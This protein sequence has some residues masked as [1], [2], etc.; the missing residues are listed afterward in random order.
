MS[1]SE[2]VPCSL[3][4]LQRL[5]VEDLAVTSD[6]NREFFAR[7]RR[8]PVKWQQ[9]PAGDLGG[10]FWAVAVHGP[11]VLW[12]DDVEEGF[13]VSR[14]EKEGLIPDDTCGFETLGKA[15]DRLRFDG[16]FYLRSGPG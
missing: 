15:L 9:H 3:A 12:Y 1:S 5:M 16:D 8:E 2:W 6:G 11:C 10:G 4:E 7:V 13:A 14:F